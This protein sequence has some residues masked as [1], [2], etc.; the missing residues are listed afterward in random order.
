[1][2]SSDANAV[3]VVGPD[4]SLTI[5]LPISVT[6]SQL[7]ATVAANGTQQFTAT[8]GNDPNLAVSWSATVGTVSSS[9]LFTAP[10]VSATTPVTVTAT[11]QADSTKAASVTLQ[12][13]SAQGA[14][15]MLLGHSTIETAVNGLPAGL[16]DGYR[17]QRRPPVP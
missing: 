4:Y 9:G 11:S 13:V 7:S 6:L 2:R 16:A 5:S 14:S 12:I 15:S 17:S 1:V 3:L 8:V 10:N